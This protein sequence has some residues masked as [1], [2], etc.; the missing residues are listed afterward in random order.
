[1]KIIM[2]TMLSTLVIYTAFG[3]NFAHASLVDDVIIESVTGSGSNRAFFVIDFDES[4]TDNSF[5]F[6]YRWD[7]NVSS[8][9]GWDMLNAIDAAESDLSVASGGEAGV[10]FGVFIEDVT[11]RSL[12]RGSTTTG[13]FWAY[14]NAE[15]ADP[16]LPNDWTLAAVSISARPVSNHSWDG[17]SIPF[18]SVDPF[19]APPA[20]DVSAVPLPASVWALASA[21]VCLRRFLSA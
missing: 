16:D 3:V 11:Y 1:M 14:W 18:G 21:L 6:E 15:G 8:P 5:T 7:P 13:E 19:P 12:S 17:L 2:S 9:T 4:S 20:P 10:G